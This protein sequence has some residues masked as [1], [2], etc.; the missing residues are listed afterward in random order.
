M[1]PDIGWGFFICNYDL[2]SGVGG[3]DDTTSLKLRSAGITSLKLRGAGITVLCFLFLS[4]PLSPLRRQGWGLYSARA[5]GQNKAIRQYNFQD[6]I[7]AFAGM[8]K[9]F[10]FFI[11]KHNCH[12]REGMT[13]DSIY[14]DPGVKPQDDTTSLKLR[15]AGTTSLKLRGAGPTVLCFLFFSASVSCVQNAMNQARI[16]CATVQDVAF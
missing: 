9:V 11:L 4:T 12:P 10:N 3:Q 2:D 15:G 6:P 8:T 14:L 5:A 16:V 7:P 13:K 1:F